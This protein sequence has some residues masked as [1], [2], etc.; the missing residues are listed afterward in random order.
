MNWTHCPLAAAV[1]LLWAAV[2]PALTVHCDATSEWRCA[3]RGG[4][5]ALYVYLRVNGVACKYPDLAREQR[6]AV[7]NGPCTASTLRCIAAEYGLSLEPVRLN[8]GELFR[9]ARP[10]IV[11][12][13]GKSPDAGAFMLILSANHGNVDYLNGPSAAIHKLAVRDFR[14][15]WSGIALLPR[16]NQRTA[17]WS[18]FIGFAI[19]LIGLLVSCALRRVKRSRLGRDSFASAVAVALLVGIGPSVG[20]AGVGLEGRRAQRGGA[21]FALRLTAEQRA[22]NLARSGLPSEVVAQLEKQ[23]TAMKRVAVEYGVGPVRYK[24]YFDEGR[25]YQRREQWQGFKTLVHENAFD[26]RIMYF[27]DP[28]MPSATT[29]AALTKFLVADETDPVRRINYFNFAFLD[30]AG[31]YAPDCV[32]DLNAMPFLEPLALYYLEEGDPA[33]IRTVGDNLLLT[34]RVTDRVLARARDVDVNQQRNILKAYLRRKRI[35]RAVAVERQIEKIKRL[36]SM[37]P[38][39]VLS[40]LLDSSRGYALADRTEQTPAGQEIRRIHTVRWKHFDAVGIWLPWRFAVFKY[41]NPSL[42]RFTD[43]PQE[44]TFGLSHVDFNPHPEVHFRL[45]YTKPG[46]AIF[47]RAAP[48]LTNGNHMLRYTVAANGALVRGVAHEVMLELSRAQRERRA[49]LLLGFTLALLAIGAILVY[50]RHR[51]GLGRNV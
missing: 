29:P 47:D 10:I 45:D 38:T 48:A 33:E 9:C 32:A 2:A 11:C 51:R 13:D 1:L 44:G 25:F 30:A 36:Q 49:I 27:G 23:M 17:V 39:R 3:R 18:Y 14:R 19:G 40:L 41:A 7:G 50:A 31:Y 43:K 22:S 35:G 20:A 24:E 5:N 37:T 46:T 42:T 15:A 8:L 21:D 4:V 26:R 16:A 6:R 12:M 34:I 28:D